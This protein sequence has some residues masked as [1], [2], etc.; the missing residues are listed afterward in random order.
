[1]SRNWK[2]TSSLLV[3]VLGASV[4]VGLTAVPAAA[5]TG[6]APGTGLVG[7]CN[8]LIDQSMVSGPMSHLPTQGTAG[9]FHAVDVSGCS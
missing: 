8:M 6:A 4:S 5:A 7:A 3:A 9:M 1:M 2:S